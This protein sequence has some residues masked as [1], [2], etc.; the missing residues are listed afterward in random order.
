MNTDDILL[1]LNCVLHQLKATRCW[2]SCWTPMTRLCHFWPNFI[3]TE[4]AWCMHVLTTKKSLFNN[5]WT[6]T[7]TLQMMLIIFSKHSMSHRWNRYV[8]TLLLWCTRHMS[9][10]TVWLNLTL[11]ED[12]NSQVIDALSTL[13]PQ[14]YD[15]APDILCVAEDCTV[16]LLHNVNVVAGLVTSQSGTVVKV[17]FNN[18]DVNLVIA[19]EHALPC[20]K[21]LHV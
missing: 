5:F 12:I 13:P 4:V 6:V 14:A 16:R 17:I 18:A 7:N 9:A 2:T 11:A 20:C 1:W 15:Y 3:M 19:E 8:T 10:S 21:L